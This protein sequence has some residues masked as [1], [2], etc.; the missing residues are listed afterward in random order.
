MKE[1]NIY[2]T[3]DGKKIDI[4]IENHFGTVAVD[5]YQIIGMLQDIQSRILKS[6]AEGNPEPTEI[7]GNLN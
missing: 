7:T 1:L 4:K 2:I 6:I 3:D 5:M